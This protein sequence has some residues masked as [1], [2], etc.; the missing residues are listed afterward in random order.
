MRVFR[1]LYSYGLIM[2]VKIM[3]IKSNVYARESPHIITLYMLHDF[4]YIFDFKKTIIA[5]RLYYNSNND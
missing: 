3:L 5:H 1:E 4:V 2:V